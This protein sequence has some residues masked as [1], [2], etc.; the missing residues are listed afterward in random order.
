MGPIDPAAVGGLVQPDLFGEGGSPLIPDGEIVPKVIGARILS[1][2]AEMTAEKP[3]RN[4][5]GM[6]DV[7]A[8]LLLVD[9]RAI[10][11]SCYYASLEEDRRAPNGVPNGGVLGYAN[12]LIQALRRTAPTHVLVAFDHPNGADERKRLL[13]GYKGN[14][15][16]KTL[17]HLVQIDQAMRLTRALGLRCASP[18]GG[19]ADD[20]I[21]TVVKRAP[22]AMPVTIVSHDKD[23][24]HLLTRP[25]TK[26]LWRRRGEWLG[27]E[28]DA[29]VFARLGVA[30]HQVRDYLALVGDS[31]DC[32]PGCPGIG[33]KTARELLAAHRTIEGIFGSTTRLKIA[34]A[35][36]VV[37]L[38]HEGRAAIHAARS[39]VTLRT[40]LDSAE[41]PR[42]AFDVRRELA[43]AR[44]IPSMSDLEALAQETGLPWLIGEARSLEQ[45]T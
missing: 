9:G 35:A 37:K 20:A 36:H 16:E 39:V 8:H 6:S 17:E 45:L 30:A 1:S 33:D 3:R 12:G 13:P 44:R 19:E 10:L 32:V 24:L 40:D 23:L 25:H 2:I 26:M 18:P 34:R 27:G 11:D 21:A 22:E 4:V 29:A 14:R 42:E 43:W 15:A 31:S 38:L 7:H 28:G 5:E 41:L